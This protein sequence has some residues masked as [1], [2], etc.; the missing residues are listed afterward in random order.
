MPEEQDRL[1]KR[2]RFLLEFEAAGVKHT[3]FTHDMSVSGLFVCSIRS[4]KPGTLVAMILRRSKDEDLGLTG[5][6]VRSFRGP[7]ALASVM[8]SGFGVRFSENPPEEYF[9]LLASL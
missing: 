7:A 6:V 2:R 3:G 9:R 1:R 4:P 5:V 8:P